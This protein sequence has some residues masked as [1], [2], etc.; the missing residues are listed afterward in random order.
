MRQH[1]GPLLH[2]L[3]GLGQI[4]RHEPARHLLIGLGPG[5]MLGAPE[6]PQVLRQQLAATHTARIVV[7]IV[8][9]EVHIVRVDARVFGI[10]ILGRV[11]REIHVED[12]VVEDQ[13]IG[14]VG[15]EI[16]QQPLHLGIKHT[17][18]FLVIVKVT[19]CGFAVC[20]RNTQPVHAFRAVGR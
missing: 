12:V 18:D 3:H 5:V 16:Q 14:G 6:V 20:Q 7:E 8:V 2:R 13:G 9:D 10:L 17:F 19:A 15:E 11:T 4:E 1:E